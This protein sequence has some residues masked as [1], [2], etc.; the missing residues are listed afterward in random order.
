[1]KT[2]PKRLIPGLLLSIGVVALHAQERSVDALNQ[3]YLNW[4]NKDFVKDQILGTSVDRVY[5]EL[6]SDKT[7]KKTVVVA[8][9]DSGVDI[10]HEDLQGRIWLNEDEIPDNNIDDDNNGYVD[11]VH[12]WN[13]LGNKSGQ[14]LVYDNLECTRLYKLGTGPYFEKA[15]DLYDQLLEKRTKEKENIA[16]FTKNLALAKEI[17][18]KKT[19]VQVSSQKDLDMITDESP[20]VLQAKKFLSDRYEKG[21]KDSM[22]TEM[23]S[24][25]ELFLTKYLNLEFDGRSVVGD[26]PSDINDRNYGNSDVKGPRCDHGTFV[27]GVIAAVRDNSIGINGIASNVKLMILRTTPAG[28]ER[29]KD[30]ALAI[31]YAVDNGADIINMSFGKGLSP[32]KQFVDQAVRAAE[33]RNVLIIHGSGNDGVDIDKEEHFP[34]SHYLDGTKA[35]NWITVGASDE[36][37]DEAAAPFSSYG[38]KGVDIFAPGVNVISTDSSNRYSMHDGVSVSVPVV[39][40]VVALILSYYPSLTPPQL[41]S[42]LMSSSY[43]V[44][45]KVNLPGLSQS[46]PRKVKF[47]SLS[48]SGGIVNAYSAMETAAKVK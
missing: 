31:Q 15:K 5:R 17:I 45:Q 28:D 19:G 38:A 41:I 46:E 37:S 6:L 26:D 2:G 20:D 30:V 7:P 34:S 22:L 9:L 33:A 10:N 3:K 14:N 40:G 27:A 32:Q 35:T 4:Q 39:S 18:R 43:K 11:D 12:G 24:T 8:I 29:D 1:M 21:F 23:T 25:N 48:V 36:V 16:R 47:S 13:F 42:I 44:N